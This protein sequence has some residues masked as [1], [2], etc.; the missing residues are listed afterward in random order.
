MMHVSTQQADSPREQSWGKVG[1]RAAEAA[2]H[3]VKA[4][5]PVGLAP[6]VKP[7]ADSPEVHG[8]L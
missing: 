8:V 5:G 6:R 7:A 3:L 4:A 1:R 2:G